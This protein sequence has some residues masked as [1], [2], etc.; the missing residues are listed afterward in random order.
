M[1]PHSLLTTA[2][3]VAALA[4]SP[5]ATAHA[6]DWIFAPSY[7]THDP[8]SGE[9][10][11][12]YTPIGPFYVY[13][14]G[15]YLE[16]GYTH[17]Q[18]S[19]QVGDSIDNLHITSR[20]GAPVRPYGEWQFPYRPYSVPY[21]L[22]GPSYYLSSPYPHGAY[23]DGYYG[24]HG[25]YGDAPHGGKD[26]P[27]AGPH[28]KAYPYKGPG[29]ADSFRPFAPPGGVGGGYSAEF[30]GPWYNRDTHAPFRGGFDPR[31]LPPDHGHGKPDGKKH[32][33]DHDHGH[34]HGG[35]P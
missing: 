1:R 2:A 5:S 12:Q 28:G 14:R 31:F 7:Y 22:W 34:E 20:W 13:P 4:G 6:A 23:G 27:H 10:V 26:H 33:K 16:S 3:V 11:S 32:H 8:H 21:H 24:G 19:L 18:S 15:D 25:G 17:T 30:P 35:M 9:R 29:S